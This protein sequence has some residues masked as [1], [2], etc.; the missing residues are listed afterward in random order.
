MFFF[1]PSCLL[2]DRF[3]IGRWGLKRRGHLL[4][5]GSGLDHFT[6]HF[7]WLLQSLLM[8]SLCVMWFFW[9]YIQRDSGPSVTENPLERNSGHAFQPCGQC[10]SLTPILVGYLLTWLRVATVA[11]SLFI[12][13]LLHMEPGRAPDFFSTPSKGLRELWGGRLSFT[14]AQHALSPT[15]CCRSCSRK[16]PSSEISPQD[17][18]PKVGLQIS[19]PGG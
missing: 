13:Q 18:G 1:T 6:G 7:G 15:S 17:A 2:G 9:V 8:W 10:T 14:Q 5:V 11:A 12:P 3:W 16:F 4:V 19:R